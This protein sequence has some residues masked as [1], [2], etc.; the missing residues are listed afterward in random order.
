MLH[1]GGSHR[2]QEGLDAAPFARGDNGFAKL[3]T[4]LSGWVPV[5]S[6][7]MGPAF[8]APTN[9][10]ALSDFVPIVEGTG[11]SFSEPS[12]VLE[13]LGWMSSN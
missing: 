13:F 6:V 4:A 7:I 11:S 8:A 3:Q 5:I 12:D 2:I 1:D 10:A 9:F